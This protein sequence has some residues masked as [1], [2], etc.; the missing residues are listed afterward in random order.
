MLLEFQDEDHNLQGQA[1]DSGGRPIAVGS[2]PHIAKGDQVS[3]A[4]PQVRV[5]DIAGNISAAV[6]S[7]STAPGTIAIVTFSQPFAAPPL[8][9]TINDHSASNADLYVSDRNEKGFTVSTRRSLGSD[10]ILN[11][12]YIVAA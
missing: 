11:F 4:H 2:P 10:S 5:Q 3:Y 1:F 6:R 9:V 12:D 8:A 7:D